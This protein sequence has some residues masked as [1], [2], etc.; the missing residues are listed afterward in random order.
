MWRTFGRVASLCRA[1]SV[2]RGD[3]P[4]KRRRAGALAN[5]VAACAFT[6]AVF[7]V[8]GTQLFRGRLFYCTDASYPRGA[9]LGADACEAYGPDA[10]CGLPRDWPGGCG[11]AAGASVAG[12]QKRAKFPTSKAPISASF[13]S[14]RLTFGRAIISRNGLEAR[15]LFPE[16]ARAEHSR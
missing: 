9:V 3:S 4:S 10:S 14:F 15:M 13:H 7:A 6:V 11:G 2:E 16:R 1:L 5:V 12:Q 8:V